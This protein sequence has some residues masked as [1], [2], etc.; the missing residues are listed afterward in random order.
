M[1]LGNTDI[2]TEGTEVLLRG[3]DVLLEALRLLLEVLLMYWEALRLLQK[4]L[5]CY[6]S[7]W[8]L[9]LLIVL[10]LYSTG[11]QTHY[12]F[13]ADSTIKHRS[14]KILRVI[15]VK[16]LLFNKPW[17]VKKHPKLILKI[18]IIFQNP[19]QCLLINVFLNLKVV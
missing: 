10:M 5:K 4:V 16:I 6:W 19:C 15:Q 13:Y 12:I 11:C 9:L 18:S 8:V 2:A 17:L 3:T 7:Y 14:E 1:I